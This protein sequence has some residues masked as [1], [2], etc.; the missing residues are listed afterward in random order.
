MA[1]SLIHFNWSF[2]VTKDTYITKIS[3][4]EF[5][6]TR[7]G[8]F[9]K[10][11]DN[12]KMPAFTYRDMVTKPFILIKVCVSLVFFAIRIN[13]RF[14]ECNISSTKV[15]KYKES[16]YYCYF[17]CNTLSKHLHIWDHYRFD[18]PTYLVIKEPFNKLCSYSSNFGHF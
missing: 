2:I 13:S 4:P 1:S 14:S 7:F 17:N 16:R 6:F 10:K 18:N 8:I 3:W 15:K 11:T 12:S 5:Q 9:E